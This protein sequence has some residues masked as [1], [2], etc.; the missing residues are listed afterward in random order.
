MDLLDLFDDGLEKARANE[1]GNALELQKEVIEYQPEKLDVFKDIIPS[2]TQRKRYLL[3]E[4]NEKQ[5][6][7]WLV[8]KALSFQQD[9]IFLANEMNR[10]YNLPKRLQYDYYFHSV[11]AKSRPFR[12]HKQA[13][14]HLDLDAVKLYF[15][16]S[17]RQAKSALNI[18]TEDQLVMIRVATREALEKRKATTVG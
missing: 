4:D 18:L 13:K 10:N 6:E 3:D 7:P 14:A 15:G 17:G 11:R 2:L 1:L 12:W 9:N 16:Y 8:N 5:Y